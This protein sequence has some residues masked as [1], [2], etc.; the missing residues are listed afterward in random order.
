MEFQHPKAPSRQTDL[1][2][3]ASRERDAELTS[4]RLNALL[5]AN[6]EIA[7]EKAMFKTE[8]NRLEA[9]TMSA[10]LSIKKSFS[11]FGLMLGTFPPAA[12]FLRYAMDSGLGG[13]EDIWIIPVILI[14]NLVSAIVG[15]FTGKVVGSIFASLERAPWVA[16]LAISPLI[17]LLWGI[18]AGGAGG[19]IILI[20][21]ALFGAVIGGLVGAA[22]LPAFAIGHRALQRGEMIETKHFL[23]LSFGITLTICSFILGL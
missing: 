6:A 4:V 12:V 17:G 9:E 11:Y 21:G 13:S 14:V 10:P 16:M 5:D 7:R 8:A 22:A 15:F 3:L 1:N 18:A 20:V 2:D 19:F 23:P